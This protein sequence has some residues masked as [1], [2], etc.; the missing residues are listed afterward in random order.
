MN[1][2]ALPTE[3]VNPRTQGLDKM[4]PRFL[5]RAFNAED[6]NAARAVQKANKEI[7]AVIVLAAQ[8]YASKKKI[9]FMEMETLEN[10]L[11]E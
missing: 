6:F 11:Y 1:T 10:L 4:T 9:I 7:A 3:Q 2:N 8:A 5:A